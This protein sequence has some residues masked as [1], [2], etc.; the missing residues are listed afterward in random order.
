MKS[1]TISD[2]AAVSVQ[3]A[4]TDVLL[5]NNLKAERQHNLMRAMR[6]N[7]HEHQ[8]VR[9][10]FE[11]RDGELFGIECAVIAV[12]DDHVML[13]SGFFIPVRSIQWI[14]LL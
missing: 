2:I 3:F 6:L 13:K 7:Y 12:S 8:P 1:I 10:F 9:V 4:K 14:E 11:N 5:A